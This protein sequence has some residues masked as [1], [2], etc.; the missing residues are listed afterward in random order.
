MPIS[1]NSILGNI[2]EFFFPVPLFGTRKK[3]DPFFSWGEDLYVYDL[4][5]VI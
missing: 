1:R 2:K 3:N 5:N 4:Q